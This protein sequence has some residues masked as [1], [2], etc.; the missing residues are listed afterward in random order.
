MRSFN[1]ALDGV[2]QQRGFLAY[3]LWPIS[4][5]YRTGMGL[6]RLAYESGL[7]TIRQFGV[8]IVI[9]GN[10]SVGGTGK[11]PIVVAIARYLSDRGWK[12]GIVSRGYGGKSKQWPQE[13]RMTSSPDAVGDEAV[14]LARQTGCPVV[15]DPDRPAA[16][17]KILDIHECDVILADDG[18]QHLALDR[19]VEI[20][21]VDGNRK[22]GNGFCLPAGPLREPRSRLRS[23]D[24]VIHNNSDE[25]DVRCELRGETAV[26]L[27]DSQNSKPLTE[28]RGLHVHAVAGIGNPN[29]FFSHLRKFGLDITEHA[30][31]DHHPFKQSDLAFERDEVVLMTEKDG[32]KCTPFARHKMWYV[33]VE[34]KL[35]KSFY[36]QLV[37]LLEPT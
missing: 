18:L 11:T 25:G 5:L 37:K 9:V 12:P 22:F 34:A 13:V 36:N 10:I 2:W 19:D 33:P 6:R 7:M 27:I 14:L 29:R 20:A 8:P 16:V 21:V 30:F 35:D 3:L 32:V 28:F 31:P 17:A 15:V 23:V 26:S 1:D 4:I 24:F